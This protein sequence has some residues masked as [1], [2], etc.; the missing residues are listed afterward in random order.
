MDVKISVIMPSL[1]VVDYIREAVKSVM[2]QTLKELEIICIDAG[3]SD[4]TREIID[5]L[6]SID[7]RIRVYESEKRSYGYQINK[8][9][10]LAKGKYVAVV[11]TDDYVCPDM[12]ERLYI[13][14]EKHNV[15]Y[16][17]ANYHSFINQEKGDRFFLKGN[18]FNDDRLYG[19]VIKPIDFK[20]TTVCD[21]Y[22]WSG[23]YRKQFLLDKH[24]RL[25]ET[26]GAAYQDIG[27]LHQVN[28]Y[29]ERAFYVKDYGY[30][31]CID[32]ETSSSNSGKGLIF[33]YNEFNNLLSLCSDGM[34]DNS[35]VL[36]PLYA[37]MIKVFLGCYYDIL[38]C[39]L[40]I[41]D[42]IEGKYKWFTEEISKAVKNNIISKSNIDENMW[43]ALYNT[44]FLQ[45]G[46]K[47]YLKKKEAT[48]VSCVGAP[49]ENKIVIFSCG[50]Y[51]FNA[52]KYLSKKG[53]NIVAFTDNNS[54]LWHKN[55]CGVPIK[56]PKEIFDDYKNVRYVIANEKYYDEIKQ[57]LLNEGVDKE[58]V[59]IF[60]M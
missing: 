27:F 32:R 36:Y 9:V 33:A 13:S 11:E 5:E 20:E 25:N 17:K 29:A 19:K 55:L 41:E 57:Q 38:M 10:E 45:E 46:Y 3:S 4:G 43:E 59:H 48:M 12:Y 6:A 23:I 56:A 2:N 21:W 54:A 24:I 51:G 58:C 15:D 53:Y 7:K 52:Y 26:K 44:I 8:G 35:E 60:N 1:N 37:R 50:N 40:S 28:I 18:I 49:G 42:E 14:A 39:K 47:L 34:S 16:V 22:I 31:Y 30:N